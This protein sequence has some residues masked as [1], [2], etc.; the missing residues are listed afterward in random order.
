M[1]T[2]RSVIFFLVIS[3]FFSAWP[4]LAEMIG[5][6]PG[7]EVELYYFGCYHFPSCTGDP[8]YVSITT[9]PTHGTIRW[10]TEMRTFPYNSQCGTMTHLA[11]VLYYTW[12]D[13]ASDAPQDNLSLNLLCDYNYKYDFEIYPIII[14]PFGC[15]DASA[16]DCDNCYK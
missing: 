14:P 3:C 8:G 4:A 5:V 6:L 1:K 15:P 12:D 2:L 10:A 13:T 9:A 11:S 7:V 16:T